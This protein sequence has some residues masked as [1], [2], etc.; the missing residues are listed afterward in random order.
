MG[1][2]NSL[3]ELL[4]F[5]L[6]VSTPL[7]K[8]MLVELVSRSCVFRIGDRVVSGFKLAGHERLSCDIENGLVG[9]TLCHYLLLLEGGCISHT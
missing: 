6:T 7:R 3:L 4:E 2:A 8:T 5:V 9:G 1:H